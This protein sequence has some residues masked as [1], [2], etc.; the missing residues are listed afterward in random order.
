MAAGTAE[1]PPLAGLVGVADT[2]DISPDGRTVIAAS[3]A[4]EILMW[5]LGTGAI[6][7]GPFPGPDPSG[8]LAASFTPDGSRMIVV[9]DSGSGWIW[10]V[11]PASWET[12]A[13]RIAG[14]SL[15]LAEW[16]VHL[17]DRP[18]HATCGS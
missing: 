14:R 13:C 4:G 7:G 16:E 9:S 1:G 12:R 3:N 15:T 8:W 10:D 11:D 2:V 18:Y 6:L 17:P 5:D